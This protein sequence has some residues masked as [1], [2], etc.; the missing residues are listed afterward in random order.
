MVAVGFRLFC[1]WV[2]LN[3]IEMMTISIA[4]NRLIRFGATRFAE[5]RKDRILQL[6]L[7]EVWCREG[8]SNPH[9]VALGGF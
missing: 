4:M 3:A 8:G 5:R 1:F 6:L 9:E 2:Q 7:I